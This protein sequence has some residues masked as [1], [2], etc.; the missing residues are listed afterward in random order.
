MFKVLS[1]LLT[2][3]E[4]SWLQ[5]L[6]EIGA[7]I[8]QKH[9][10]AFAKLS[11]LLD[12]LAQQDII[13][14]QE[15]YVATFDRGRRHS[16]H[17]FEHLHGEDRQRGQAMVDLLQVYQ[18]HDV[19]PQAH[20][21]PDYLPL[22]L[23]FLALAPQELAQEMLDDAVHVIHHIG[24][25]L[26]QDQSV[27]ACLFTVLIALSTVPAL[28]LQVAPVRD[29]DEAMQKFGPN[30]EGVEPLLKPSDGLTH[31]LQFYPKPRV[32]Q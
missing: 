18:A 30:A 13:T 21:L 25:N 7:Y 9:P 4:A 16:L 23:E 32:S 2:Y 28:P 24:Q 20:E 29:M 12:Y 6:P 19:L 27:Y 31:T 5:E 1:I 26:E 14:V 3:P 17:L 22:F 10:D 11:P 15:N 8:K